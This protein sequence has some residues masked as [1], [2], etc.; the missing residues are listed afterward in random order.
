MAGIYD[1]KIFD[2]R[3]LRHLLLAVGL[4][5]VVGLLVVIIWLSIKVWLSVFAGV[6][7][8]VFF[9]TLANW[10]TKAT[11]LRGAWA[12]AAVLL[13]LVG[14]ATL[15]GW[16]VAP[17]LSEQ[18]TQL[19][20]RLPALIDKLHERF[21]ASGWG[22]YLPQQFPSATEL[23]S[24]IG[25]VASRIASFSKIS[26]E[27]VAI[28][29]VIVFLGIYLA[30]APQVYVNG[31]IRMFPPG[32]RERVRDILDQVGATL[33][34]WLLG[35]MISMT[36]VGTLI[37]V[38]LT[39]LGVPLGLALGVL[40]GLLNFIP[41]IGAWLS[42]A[43]AILLA[44]LV[45]PL[46]PLYVIALYLVVNTGIESHLLIPLIQRYAINLPPALAVVALF[47]MS[48]LFGFLGVLLAIPAIAT[49]LVL[50]K[51]IYLQ[52][53]LGDHVGQRNFQRTAAP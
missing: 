36:V 7:L 27:A 50:I 49:L 35:Q 29:F 28:F 47:L 2:R 33:G 5:L 32:K 21:A 40:A 25:G 51:T 9:R 44:F 34:N 53:V 24:S 4:V 23:S 41:I 17:K 12:L 6:L 10:V 13:V 31:V 1:S 20:Q 45:S 39:L 19:T 14:L 15:G 22:R 11:H 26:T 46:H 42:A 18:F 48:Q 3:Y 37:G 52:D 30:A 8:A 43:P 38:G 16:L